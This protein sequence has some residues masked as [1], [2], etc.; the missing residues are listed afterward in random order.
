MGP[1]QQRPPPAGNVP[2][3]AQ[4]LPLP[5]QLQSVPAVLIAFFQEISST[6]GQ[7]SLPYTSVRM[8]ASVTRG[9]SRR[10]TMK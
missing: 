7:W 9:K 2:A 4:H 10:D 8:A 1:G 3:L 5:G 6:T